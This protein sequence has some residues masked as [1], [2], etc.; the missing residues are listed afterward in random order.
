MRTYF[1]IRS[2]EVGLLFTVGFLLC[3]IWTNSS[4]AQQVMPGVTAA[5]PK[6]PNAAI[7][8]KMHAVKI[9]SPTKGQQVPIG[10]DLVVS[11][12]SSANAT[13]NCQ[14]SVIANHIRPYQ[15]AVASGPGGTN[16]Y[17]NW[18]FTLTPKYTAIKEGQNKITAK[19]SCSSNPSLVSYSNVNVTGIAAANQSATTTPPSTSPSQDISPPSTT[20]P[21]LATITNTAKVDSVLLLMWW[22]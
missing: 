4:H 19:Y 22:Q 9:T 8:P 14:V 17:S 7:S 13:S 3:A 11:G 21:T 10:N 5:T 15:P 12:T 6:A 18:T 20:T 1:K 16:D 2:S